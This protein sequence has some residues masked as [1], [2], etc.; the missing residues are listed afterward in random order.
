MIN[1]QLNVDDS[2]PNIDNLQL[3]I[4]NL[5]LI[6]NPTH[7]KIKQ[8]I[9]GSGLLTKHKESPHYSIK[10]DYMDAFLCECLN[11]I[12]MQRNAGKPRDTANMVNLLLPMLNNTLDQTTQR[13]M[14]LFLLEQKIKLLMEKGKSF[15][16]YLLPEEVFLHMSD[17]N[18][19]LYRTA[20]ELKSKKLYY[21]PK[22]SEESAYYVS[23]N[24]YKS[25][26]IGKE[27]LVNIEQI[28]PEWHIEVLRAAA[29]NTG[30]IG[31]IHELNDIASMAGD[32]IDMNET[33]SLNNVAF[34]LEGIARAY[35]MLQDERAMDYIEKARSKIKIMKSSND[36]TDLREVQLLR[37]EARIISKIGTER[38]LDRLKK[39]GL[40]LSRE[41]RYDRYIREFSEL[42]WGR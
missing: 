12:Q 42:V 39:K 41:N 26:A 6:I 11:M 5:Q 38:E 40:R 36:T 13:G 17:V 28:D 29:I 20:E 33:V 24:Y 25:Y 9:V 22:I 23:K 31:S 14:R 3:N 27:L 1:S 15:M 34:L 21:L 4:A 32:Y 30:Y 8:E 37:T 16:D 19:Q 10:K 7:S 18:E 2:Q 35:G